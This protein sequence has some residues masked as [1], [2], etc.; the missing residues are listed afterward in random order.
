MVPRVVALCLAL[1]V[2]M[3]TPAAAQPASGGSRD[4]VRNGALLGAVI[5]AAAAATAAAVI[6]KAYQ[7]KG[8]PSCVPDTLRFSALGGAI[9]AGAGLAIDVAR[10]H[11]GVTVRFEVRF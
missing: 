7:E 5:G 1:S 6:C 8:G 2:V 4:S 10:S 11:R 3:P 9:G